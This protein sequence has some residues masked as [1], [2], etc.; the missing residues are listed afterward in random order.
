MPAP[1]PPD[2]YVNRSSSPKSGMS[3]GVLTPDSLD[4]NL[5]Y[6]QEQQLRAA[7]EANPEAAWRLRR[8]RMILQVVPA[9]IV[10][11]FQLMIILF[12]I[13]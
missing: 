6:R 13:L 5:E 4:S 12:W 7:L 9:V 10:V 1:L 8:N 3:F 11:V 2:L